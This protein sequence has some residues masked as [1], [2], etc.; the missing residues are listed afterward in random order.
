MKAL[1]KAASAALAVTFAVIGLFL[2]AWE[3]RR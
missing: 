1:K 2:F 3:G